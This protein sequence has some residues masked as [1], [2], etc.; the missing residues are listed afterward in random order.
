MNVSNSKWIIVSNRLPFSYNKSNGSLVRSSG[1]LVTA[2]EG[3][4][5]GVPSV[6][7]GIG[8]EDAPAALW[9]TANADAVNDR[10][11]FPVTVS[12]DLYE[13][14]YN[15]MGNKVL[16]PLFHYEIN[17]VD[18]SLEYWD[19]YR[20]VNQLIADQVAAIAQP[21][22]LIWLHDFHLMLVPELLR[23]ARVPCKIG[24]FLHTPFP[25]SEL[26]RQ[27]PVRK[28]LIEGLL[29]A[30]LV[31]FHDYSYLRHFAS[32][33]HT[34]LGVD[35]GG[36]AIRS[37]SG[38]CALGV[39][40][41]SIDT[42]QIIEATQSADVKREVKKLQTEPY[43]H[44]ILGVDRLDYSKGLHLRLQTF[45]RFLDD[46]PEYHKKVGMLQIAIPSRV[47]VPGYQELRDEVERMVGNIN[48]RFGASDY[49]PVRYVFSSVP[50]HEL[51]AL[52]QRADVL[53]VTSRRDGM[54]LVALEYVAAQNPKSPG[55]V[56]LS[57]FAGASSLL[58]HAMTINPWDIT[59]CAQQI[60][61]AIRM[62]VQERIRRHSIMMGFLSSYTA[63][64]WARSFIE[65]LESSGSA[66]PSLENL[67]RR[68][69]ADELVEKLPP[70]N[71]QRIILF[72]DFDGTLTAVQKRPELVKLTE[73]ARSVLLTL[74]QNPNLEIVVVSGRDKSYL[75][76]EFAEIPVFLAAEHGCFLYQKNF[77]KWET[78]VRASAEQWR[79]AVEQVLE[80]YMKRVPGSFVERK[81]FCLAWHYREAPTEFAEY[82]A[83]RLRQDLDSALAN[84]P[85][86][87]LF[88]KKVI[89]VVPMEGRKSALVDLFM[90]EFKVASDPIVI[91]IGDDVTDEDMFMALERYQA[92]TIKVGW[93][94]SIAGAQLANQERV[95]EF[96]QKLGEYAKRPQ[97][98]KAENGIPTH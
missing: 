95:I 17:Q 55:S 48:G 93:G 70:F 14:Y 22:D 8:P 58:S 77:G 32:T 94:P 52:Y 28:E 56:L 97:H 96:L 43:E 67:D 31:G 11:Y 92:L 41:V 23:R 74:T 54:N 73:A 85:V 30:D 88:G 38:L 33:V 64:D 86:V 69:S 20:Q 63:T 5:S 72:L 6:W 9:E 87:V 76:N 25:S 2:I 27:L 79:P 90:E 83:R 81:E 13:A 4:H 68:N 60:A 24:F 42:P 62:P 7:I 51:I 91:G 84:S 61:E 78:L 37:T 19:A 65:A 98:T 59:G 82:Q 12:N 10:R 47:E 18:F 21:G 80:H 46:F 34:V 40:P 75:A 35:T 3:I 44:V 50:F 36:F 26:F 39:F 66:A 49:V 53:L 29:A 89:E 15:G 16:W 45:S 71:G 57:E 1:G